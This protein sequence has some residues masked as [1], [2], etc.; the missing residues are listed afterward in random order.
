MQADMDDAP[1]YLEIGFKRKVKPWLLPCVLG[2]ATC[3]GLLYG[4]A[5]LMSA[6]LRVAVPAPVE[7]SAWKPAARVVQPDLPELSSQPG[8]NKAQPLSR[9]R[10]TPKQAERRNADQ[11]PAWGEGPKQSVFNAR[12]Y[13][14]RGTVN[15]LSMGSDYTAPQ[16]RRQDGLVVKGIREERRLKDFCP[17]P[18]SIAGRDCRQRWGLGVRNR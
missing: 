2:T 11:A 8:G 10:A 17:D 3:L 5:S 9:P 1:G 13:V 6:P 7:V 14:P 12:N 18:S 4:A 15:T 16:A